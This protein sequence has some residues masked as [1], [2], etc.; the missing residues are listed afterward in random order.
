MRSQFCILFHQLLLIVTLNTPAQGKPPEVWLLP[1][2]RL[3]TV[4]PTSHPSKVLPLIKRFLAILISIMP[5]GRIAGIHWVERGKVVGEP[6]VVHPDLLSRSKILD[7]LIAL[8]RDVLV[9]VSVPL[10]QTGS[11]RCLQQRIA[12][13]SD[14]RQ[15]IPH[16]WKL[17]VLP[18]ITRHLNHLKLHTG[19]FGCALLV[20][21]V[22]PLVVFMATRSPTLKIRN[23][24]EDRRPV[25]RICI[26]NRISQRRRSSAWFHLIRQRKP[27]RT[28]LPGKCS[29]RLRAMPTKERGWR[30]K[31]RRPVR[32]AG[33]RGS[34]RC[35]IR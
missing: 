27:G 7:E 25:M 21:G 33:R 22:R 6:P 26:E 8:Q 35:V 11:I 23:R 15:T 9:Q 31:L 1:W 14:Y 10:G 32:P 13:G 30:S 16:D 17:T 3:V 20:A 34:R 12:A 28:R 19:S 29:G 2:L 5:F 24:R 4:N 18:L